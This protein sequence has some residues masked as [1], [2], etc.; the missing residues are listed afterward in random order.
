MLI[1]P[2]ATLATMSSPIISSNF[3]SDNKSPSGS[4]SV[5]DRTIMILASILSA[6]V[7]FVLSA[8]TV[9]LI[10]RRRRSQARARQQADIVQSLRRAQ[11]PILTVDTNVPRV[12]DM[13][14]DAVRSQTVVRPKG[15]DTKLGTLP[16]LHT[17]T[18]TPINEAPLFMVE[19][20]R[21]AS[22]PSGICGGSS[23]RG[24]SHPPGIGGRSS[25]QRIGRQV[26]RPGADGSENLEPERFKM[27]EM[28]KQIWN[29][30]ERMVLVLN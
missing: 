8:T 19:S 7:I 12:C 25:E 9:H 26:G 23:T 14:R 18:M 3:L 10:R 1:F 17:T 27:P 2:K 28:P 30:R 21:R 24:S 5:S 20:S 16:H 4:P 22:S 6:V 11:P 13:Q 15:K 29:P